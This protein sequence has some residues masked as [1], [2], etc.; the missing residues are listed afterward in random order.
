MSE[1]WTPPRTPKER[2][3]NALVPGSLTWRLRAYKAWR[4]RKPEL[5]L[6]RQ[7]VD[8]TKTSVDAGANR[9][10]FTYFLSGLSTHVY[11]YEPHPKM[12]WILSGSARARNVTL[13]SAALSDSSGS[14][15]LVIPVRETGAYSNQRATLREEL[16]GEGDGKCEVRTVRL[17]DE[18]VG[19]LGFMKIDV[20]GCELALL[21][22]A[23][24][25][26]RR[27]KPVLLIEI[28]ERWS[29]RPVE[30]SFEVVCGLGYEGVYFAE[31][32][33]RSIRSFDS[34]R[35]PSRPGTAT[36]D[37]FFLPK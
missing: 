28:D 5:R 18:E 24:E 26:I 27:H 14:E 36:R 13:S 10:V 30:E 20:E 12:F 21:R 19:S 8:P 3:V 6:L 34:V 16:A 32:L 33:L 1:A 15:T 31:G 17:D 9:G 23:E 7:F 4:K 25:T 2:L 22:G 29:G 11:A 35:D 37:F